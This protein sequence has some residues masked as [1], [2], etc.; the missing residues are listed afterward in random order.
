M[1]DDRSI[2]RAARSWIETG[3][4]AAPDHAVEAALLRI[5][6]TSQERDWHVPWRIPTMTTPARVAA[7]AAIGVLAIGGAAFL[8]G[9]TGQSNVGGLAASA[10]P[11]AIASE[12]ASPAPIVSPSIAAS[13]PPSNPS[14]L[15]LP[16]G[17]LAAGTY[18]TTP[19]A[20]GQPGAAC[21]KPPQPGCSE[22]AGASIRATFQV[23][24]G[25]AGNYGSSIW[26]A[27]EKSSAPGGATMGFTRGSWLYSDPCLTA[28]RITA[29][30]RP[31]VAVGPS[32]DEFANAL[33]DHPLL[34]ATDPVPVTL[35]GYSGK[36]VDLQLPSD[37]TGCITNY[38][39]WEP[40]V[41]AQGPSHRWH[42]WI[43][44]VDGVRVV[45]HTTDYPGTSA[46]HLAE[47]KAIVE[48]IQIEP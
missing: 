33:A 44:D 32:V 41:Y 4:T 20:P 35:A 19:F 21:M 8:I 18:V 16:D 25:W 47:L 11:S 34:D 43:L 6:T 14:P 22:S 2:E 42:L 46:Q 9:R 37:L 40:G 5:E 7:A 48:S 36:Y 31:D 28:S 38:R 24:D 10:S 30:V 15:A 29:G 26:L 27:A 39:P 13:P 17:P 45:V 1:N 12:S 3:P 23:P